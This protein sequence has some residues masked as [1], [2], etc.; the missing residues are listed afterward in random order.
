MGSGRSHHF[1]YA[2]YGGIDRTIWRSADDLNHNINVFIRPMFTPLQD[3]NL[4]SLG[5]DGGLT[6]HEPIAGGSD[7]TFGL[8]FG[9]ARV[10]NS[11]W[12]YDRDLVFY[13]PTVY[14]P[15]RGTESV[16][17][18]TYQFQAAKWWQ[19]QPYIQVMSPIPEPGSPT[20]TIQRR[21]SRTNL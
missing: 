13:E 19:I 5:V 16:L 1:N 17:E 18:A 2:F 21:K 7:D 12:G 10:S 11:A 3:R 8:G 9:V 6:V 14:T 4:I 15:V 20:R